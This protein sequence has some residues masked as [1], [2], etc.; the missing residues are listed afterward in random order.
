MITTYHIKRLRLKDY[1]L[2]P[3]ISYPYSKSAFRQ[4]VFYYQQC[5]VMNLPRKNILRLITSNNVFL[6]T[7]ELNQEE[8]NLIADVK[9]E[10]DR[11][12]SYLCC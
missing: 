10:I 3:I 9:A 11:F 5:C 6:L 1:D 7:R 4:L 2:K 12:L 8:L